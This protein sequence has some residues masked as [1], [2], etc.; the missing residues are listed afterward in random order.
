MVTEAPGRT[1][2]KPFSTAI[3][4]TES[5]NLRLQSHL[6]APTV[7]SGVTVRFRGLN[8]PKRENTHR[9]TARFWA[10]IRFASVDVRT[11]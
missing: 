7:R 3:S 5:N 8:G 10:C 4:S 9:A 2:T 11:Q 6:K 1:C